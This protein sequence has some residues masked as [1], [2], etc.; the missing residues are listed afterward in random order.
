MP[1]SSVLHYLLEFA[2]IHKY[3]PTIKI[4]LLSYK[5]VW[6]LIKVLYTRF[7]K[8]TKMVLKMTNTGILHHVQRDQMEIHSYL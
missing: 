8:L 3:M 4:K 5:K 6:M 1:G 7:L 2:Q